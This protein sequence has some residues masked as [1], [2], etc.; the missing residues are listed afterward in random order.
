[1]DRGQSG[2][3]RGGL[4]ETRGRYPVLEWDECSGGG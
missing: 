2:T 1:M 4:C 3:D